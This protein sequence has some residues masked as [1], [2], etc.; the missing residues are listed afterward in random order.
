M[1]YQNNNY[2]DEIDRMRARKHQTRRTSSSYPRNV[3]TNRRIQDDFEMVNL[4]DF[5]NNRK[6]SKK[7]SSKK[8]KKPKKRRIYRWVFLFAAVFACF[9]YLKRPMGSGYWTIAV[10]G[11]DSRDGHVGKGTLADVQIVC[12]INRKTGE[13]RLASVFRDTYLKID[14]EDNYHKINE[15]FSRGGNDQANEALEANL[16]LKIDDYATF[17]WNAVADAINILGGIDLEI[18]DKEF[19]YINAFISE[20]V[21]STGIGSVQ[22]EHSGMVHLDGVQSVAYA[23]LRLMD[24]DF[25]RTER[26]RKVLGLAMEKAKKADFKTLRILVGT[27][28]PQISTSIGLDDL[29]ELAKN[30]K[31]YY[32]GQ[33]T[34][35]PFSHTEMKIGKRDCVIPT[36]LES[37]VVQLH[38]FLY[39]D[40][41]YNPSATVK[42]ISSHIAEVSG[43]DT[44][45][46]DTESGKNVGA[47][48]QGNN[49]E[50]PPQTEA[51]T[52]SSEET[53][54]AEEETASTSEGDL[55]ESSSLEEESQTDNVADSTQAV[56]STNQS[57]ASQEVTKPD[58]PGSS[59]SQAPEQPTDNTNPAPVGP[60]VAP[61]GPGSAP[62]SQETAP[63]GPGSSLNSPGESDENRGPGV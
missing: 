58:G 35:F 31:K 51:S 56:E 55:T 60:G 20:T 28:F 48:I 11:V 37:N 23:R 17:N 36:T 21:Q 12:S 59:E 6:S 26:Q 45:G 24:T 63:I 10:Y 40:I 49:S 32:I 43:L 8:H 44:P 29:M 52:T 7:V 13:I 47:E 38:S 18:T 15:A 41:P 1:K 16:D 34:G 61:V 2:E 57:S 62:T 33:T 27:V 3:K 54:K 5:P 25:N 50:P 46:K 39:D 14:S 22:L 30:A 4:D 19:A 53:N 42:K 9:L